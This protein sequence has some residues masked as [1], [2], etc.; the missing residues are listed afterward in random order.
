MGSA[1]PEAMINAANT[2]AHSPIED[3]ANLLYC[4]D[5]LKI[6]IKILSTNLVT[7]TRYE[8]KKY[9]DDE[10]FELMKPVKG[11][12]ITTL[13]LNGVRVVGEASVKLVTN[14]INKSTSLLNFPVQQRRKTFCSRTSEHSNEDTQ[15]N[16]FF[17][18]FF[19][20]SIPNK[21]MFPASVLRFTC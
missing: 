20:L 16:L 10:D 1:H 14:D 19:F 13:V 6:S 18:N 17:I 7:T 2:F 12:A 15:R 21:H 8:G 9:F 4:I 11:A 3:R 5:Y